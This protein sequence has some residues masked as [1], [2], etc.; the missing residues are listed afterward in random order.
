MAESIYLTSGN[1]RSLICY[2][3]AEAIYDITYYFCHK[4]LDK[5][6]RTIDQ[7]IQAAR[8][9]KQNLAEGSAA[10]VTRSATEIQLKN[11]AKASLKELL[12]DYA[13]Y[14]RTRGKPR[15]TK[16]S[17]EYE[18]MRKVGREHNDSAYYMNLV[19]TRP[20]ETIANIAI[21]LLWQTDYLIAQMM[22]TLERDT[23]GAKTL[24]GRMADAYYA[25]RQRR[26]AYQ[27]HGPPCPKCGGWMHY[28][29]GEAGKLW[30]CDKVFLKGEDHCD[31]SLP[32][33]REGERAE[34]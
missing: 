33:S 2:Q 19:S 6:D 7:M 22:R 17:V 12:E 4:Y 30:R 18:A 32:Y 5:G 21:I 3:K 11:V 27:K 23:V 13:D 29:P 8:S 20:P 25:A 14:L 15:W 9:G 16:G 28:E 1:Y 24:S 10:G 34:P 26:I 31:G